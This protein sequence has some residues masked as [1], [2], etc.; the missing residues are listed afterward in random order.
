MNNFSYAHIMDG[1]NSGY[2]QPRFHGN[3]FIQLYL[4][5]IDRLHIWHPKLPPI[6]NHNA[7][8]HNHRWDMRSKIL[9]GGL[10]H[11]TYGYTTDTSDL[12]KNYD[13]VKI[14]GASKKS[15]VFS[16]VAEVRMQKKH[17]YNLTEG[18]SYSF[19]CGFFHLS[20]PMNKDEITVT[21]M[22]KIDTQNCK[23][24]AEL[25][26]EEGINYQDIVHAFDEK[27]APNPKVVLDIV[28]EEITKLRNTDKLG[29]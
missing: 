27:T 28:I 2:L 4:T 22:S 12:S 8:I 11:T 23:N 20:E 9:K 6:R 17:Y 21:L 13:V 25:L 10:S 14:A 26:V 5:S 19:K 1:L 24:W 7:M 3:G 15:A 29:K 16:K 18:S